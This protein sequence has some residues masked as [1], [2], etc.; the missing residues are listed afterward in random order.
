MFSLS[1]IVIAVIIVVA[2]L[3]LFSFV[4]IGLWISALAAGVP[5]GIGTLVGMRLRRVSPRKVI[6]PL[7]KA[8]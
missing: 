1:F 2:L 4:P 5:V 3:I 8:H 6:A 7:I